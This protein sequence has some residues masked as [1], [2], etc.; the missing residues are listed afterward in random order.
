VTSL[1]GTTSFHGATYNRYRITWSTS[2]PAWTGASPGVVGGGVRFHI[3]TTFTGVDFNQPDPIVIQNI[4]LLDA[5]S[6]ALTLHPRLPI[7]DAGTVDSA[8]GTFDANFF[9]PFTGGQL[10]LQSILIRQLPRL[11]SIESMIGAGR[12]RTFDDLPIRPWSTSK[13]G[14]KKLASRKGHARCVIARLSAKPHV[15]VTHSLGEVGVVDCSRGVPRSLGSGAAAGDRRTAPDDE[16]PICAGAIQDPFPST[17]LYVTA[18]VV[19]PKVKHYD[20]KRRKYLVGPVTSRLYFQFAGV[21][22][23]EKR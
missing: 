20:R 3:G 22:H 8:A 6:N 5:S 4:T 19:D 1:G 2:N 7:Y 21:R 12:P 14:A 15:Q 10:L 11:A 13:C 23:L 16:G 18:T 17:T 9:A